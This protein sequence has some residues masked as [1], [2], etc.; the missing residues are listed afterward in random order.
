M[1]R[2]DT[3][4]GRL[5]HFVRNDNFLSLFLGYASRLTPYDPKV[6]QKRNPA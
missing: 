2:D 3:L 5:L 6:L 4:R 1:G